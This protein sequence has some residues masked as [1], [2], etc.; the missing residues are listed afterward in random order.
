MEQRDSLERSSGE[1]PPQSTILPVN[2]KPSSFNASPQDGPP[3]GNDATNGGDPAS[4]RT[5]DVSNVVD[6]VLRSDVIEP[7]LMQSIVDM[8]I[9]GFIR[10]ASIPSLLV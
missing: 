7:T 8:L 1:A 5:G 3:I 4:L 10:S 2:E 9:C 6:G